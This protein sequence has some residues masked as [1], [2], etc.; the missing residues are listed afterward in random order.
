MK[1][2]YLYLLYF[3]LATG[4]FFGVQAPFP[5]F[6]AGGPEE[7]R[8][9]QVTSTP[10]GTSDNGVISIQALSPIVVP[11][12]LSPAP[13]DCSSYWYAFSDSNYSAWLTLNAQTD[14]QSTNRGEWRPNLPQAGSY[15]VEAYIASHH[16][17]QSCGLTY[18]Y[19]TSQASYAIHHAAGITSVTRDQQPVWSGWID[20]GTYPFDPGTGNYVTLSDLTGETYISRAVS[21]SVMR[22]TCVGGCDTISYYSISGKV[23]DQNNNPVG[24]IIVSTNTGLSGSTNSSGIY[25]IFGLT[26][27]TYTLTPDKS[28]YSFAPTSRIVT[29][30]PST[31]GRDFTTIQVIGG[32]CPEI[33]TGICRK[34]ITDPAG[35]I[36]IAAADLRN[37]NIKVALVYEFNDQQNKQFERKTVSNF[38]QENS[39]FKSGNAYHPFVAING[40]AFDCD[41]ASAGSNLGIEGVSYTINN[42]ASFFSYKQGRQ[43]L[44]ALVHRAFHPGT[45]NVGYPD[46]ITDTNFI[47]TEMLKVN[48]AVGYQ[49]TIVYNGQYVSGV[50][51]S[52]LQTAI[53]ISV[54]GR[55]LFLATDNNAVGYNTQD[56]ANA[57]IKAG[58]AKAILLD[59]G[60]SSQFYSHSKNG[61]SIYTYWK[62][63]VP[64]CGDNPFNFL[65]R[66]RRVIN[67]IAIYNASETSSA[68]RTSITSLGG[69]FRLSDNLTI[70]I[71][72]NAFNFTV[73]SNPIASTSV[74]TVTLE[75]VSQP[76][77]LTNRLENIGIFY[78]LEATYADETLAAPQKPYSITITYDEA[79]IPNEINEADLALYFWSGQNWVKESSSQIDIGANIIR[80][81]SANF[82]LW[83][84]LAPMKNETYLPFITK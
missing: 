42:N 70:G 20:L 3:V 47:S 52:G 11:P 67:S 60:R 10:N 32:Q 40:T 7:E 2:Y 61:S 56:L 24:N 13:G 14:N 57:L 25:I 62:N 37:P 6:G 33:A 36:N 35:N 44:P 26:A 80:A 45:G 79:N 17:T 1:H 58:A 22:F 83:A 27:G 21:F 39:T 41:G 82:G 75:Y 50:T 71:P 51:D 4:L 31:N 55:Y 65:G 78:E 81:N 29:V 77:T 74:N 12:T 59:G 46:F 48:F 30:G 8:Q 76:I 68:S 43:P 66:P 73:N 84:V 15:K 16:E 9:P 63:L 18:N 34:A 69:S 49:P 19:D 72:D 53:G 23:V 64:D 38:I 28:G 5:A 54:D